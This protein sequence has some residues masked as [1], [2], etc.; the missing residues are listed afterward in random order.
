MEA[1]LHYSNP[2]L[3]FFPLWVMMSAMLVNEECSMAESY[4]S[5]MT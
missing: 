3:P 4:K 1:A 2:W 5:E